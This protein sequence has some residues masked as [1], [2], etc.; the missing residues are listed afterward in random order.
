MYIKGEWVREVWYPYSLYFRL[1]V[2]TKCRLWI[3]FNCNV[4]QSNLCNTDLYRVV[5]LRLV[6]IYSGQVFQTLIQYIKRWFI[7]M[8]LLYIQNY[9]QTRCVVSDFFSISFIFEPPFVLYWSSYVFVLYPRITASMTI[10]Y[11]YIV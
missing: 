5:L 6:L 2:Q 7:I 3:L 11:I 4:L 9:I 1:M 10:S 8:R